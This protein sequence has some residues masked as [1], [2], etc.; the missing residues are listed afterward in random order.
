MDSVYVEQPEECLVLFAVSDDDGLAGAGVVL[1]LSVPEPA[2]A[3]TVG[4]VTVDEWGDHVV[5]VSLGANPQGYE[6]IYDVAP[7]GC[8]PAP[9]PDTA[10]QADLEGDTYLWVYEDGPH[11]AVFAAVDDFGRTGPV[12]QRSFNV[13]GS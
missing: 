8:S 5:R 6:V 11:C 4:E 7:G 12:V 2:V 1:R 3:P 10:E 9:D 13:S